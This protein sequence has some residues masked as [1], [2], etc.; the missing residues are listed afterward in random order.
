MYAQTVSIVHEDAHQAGRQTAAELLAQMIRPPDVVLA[1]VTSRHAPQQALDGLWSL[2]PPRTRL[3]GCSSFAEIGTEEA[4]A[5]SVT[6]MGIAFE[7]VEWA[8]F[9]LDADQVRGS[10]TTAGRALGERIAGFRPK[11]VLLLLDGMTVNSTKLVRA[12]QEP[13]GPGCPVIGGVASEGLQFVRTFEL[14]DR[15]VLEGGVVA[16]ALRGPVTLATSARAGFQPVGVTRTCTRVEDDRLI[17]ELDGESAL[18]LYK[19]FLGPDVAG[20][21]NIGAEFPLALIEGTGGDYMASDERSQVI[22][23]VRRL[24]EARG[25][26]L[27]GGDVH[28]GAKVRMTRATKG[29]LIAAAASAAAQAQRA[30]PNA[31][32]GLCFDCAGRRLV[33]GGRYQEEIRDAFAALDPKLPKI[34]FYTYGEIAPVDGTNMVHD[35]TFTLALVGTT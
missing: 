12:L 18:G 32:L 33:L 23:G 7:R 19:G 29:D 35:E 1:F 5:G 27:C 14:F 8:T 34:G 11:L 9:K 3:L 4:T 25:A 17:L 30:L 22:R 10:S 15:E 16:L 6:L 26:L 31:K 13:L 2:L 28:E 21:P 24:D 20:R